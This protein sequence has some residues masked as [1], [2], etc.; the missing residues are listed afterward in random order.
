MLGWR[1]GIREGLKILWPQGR[2]GPSPTPS[3][4]NEL[5]FRELGEDENFDPLSINK[6]V[7][8]TQSETY[9]KWQ[10]SAGRKVRRFVGTAGNDNVIFFQMIVFP[11]TQKKNYIYIPYGPVWN[12]IQEKT[13][14]NLRDKIKKITK[15]EKAVFA[16]LDFTPQVAEEKNLKKYFKRS[17]KSTYHSAA[18]QPRTEWFLDLHKPEENILKEMKGNGRYSV[19]LAIRKGVKAEIIRDNLSHYL[20][21]FYSLSEETAK[22]DGFK[23][24]DKSYYKSIFDLA[25]KEK[26]A[27]LS[28]AKYD[29]KI[30]VMDFIFMFGGIGNY[31]FGSSSS[32]FRNL[33]PTYLAQWTAIQESRKLGCQNY[34]FGGI[35]TEKNKKIYKG[36]EGLSFFKR[37]F[38]GFEVDHSDFYDFVG[39][40][41]L[42]FLYN[43]RKSLKQIF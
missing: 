20:D 38:G 27:F 39:D 43:F 6:R 31:V 29:G 1:N 15:E 23:L 4:M 11:L 2:V 18:F 32:E 16:R 9:G 34:N 30:V 36:W 25:D 42:Y 37:K 7:Y 40:G 10:K 5:V 8:F 28:I 41:F 12:N 35:A 19:N 22:R 26:N 13:I 14:S 21:T 24:H 3:T 33:M 17:R